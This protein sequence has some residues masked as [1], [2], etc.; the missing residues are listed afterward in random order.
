[1]NVITQGAEELSLECRNC[2]HKFKLKP[3]ETIIVEKNGI[4]ETRIT[5]RNAK[6]CSHCGRTK[7]LRRMPKKRVYRLRKFPFPVPKIKKL[8][9]P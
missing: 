6:R 5:K 2:G 9:T 7:F 1:M 4:S 8:A 3:V